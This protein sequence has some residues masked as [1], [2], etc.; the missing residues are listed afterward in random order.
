MAKVTKKTDSDIVKYQTEHG[1]VRLGPATIRK[2][3]V[4]GG[5]EVTDQEVMMF[6]TLCKYQKLNPFLREAYLIKYSSNSPAAIVVGKEVFTKRAAKNPIFNGF[7]AGIYVVSEDEEGEKP[8]QR[9]GSMVLEGEAV[10]GGWAEISREDW[11]TLVFAAVSFDEYA[12]RKKDGNLNRQ[13]SSKPATMIRK[14]ALVQA[15]REAFP[16]QFEGMYDISE[17]AEETGDGLPTDDVVVDAE[18]VPDSDAEPPTDEYEGESE[19][20]NEAIPESSGPD[21]ADGTDVA[22]LAKKCRSGINLMA[23]RGFISEDQYNE[24]EIEIVEKEKEGDLKGL[25]ARHKK[26]TELYQERAAHT[27]PEEKKE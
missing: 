7:K 6:L 21:T 20:G 11:D 22:A 13:W 9:N 1:E 17:M 2:Y 16:D 5:G 23:K 8:E 25:K 27:E 26:L 3:L 15:L 12:G 4:S 24:Y 19:G 14:V 10:V 18:V